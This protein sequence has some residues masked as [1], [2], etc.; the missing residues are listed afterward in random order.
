MKRILSLGAGV[1]ST[2]VLLLSISGELEPIDCAVFA[3]TG[4][5]PQAVYKHLEWLEG[6]AKEAGIPIHRIDCGRNIKEDALRATVR[7]TK[8]KGQRHANMPF[9]TINPDGSE[10]MI[11]RQCTKEYKVEPLDRKI[12]AL[13]GLKPRE[14]QRG[15]GPQVE[16][17]FGISSD[18]KQRMRLSKHWW[19]INYYPLVEDLGMTRQ[20]C[21]HWLRDRWKI[22][23]PRSACIACPYRTNEEWRWLKDHYPG[24]YQEAI[25]FD[26]AIR[27]RGGMH[28]K[29]YVHRSCRPLSEVDLSTAEDHGQARLWDD[30]CAGMCGV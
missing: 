5:E 14:R 20:D 11:R 1:Q 23:P 27:T 16:Q 22:T 30:E 3:D 17:W 26:D 12:R 29:L 13:S 18:E 25:E 2:A 9:R 24:E 15:R 21:L 28:G 8:G 10:G 7:G 19:A 4:W 6:V